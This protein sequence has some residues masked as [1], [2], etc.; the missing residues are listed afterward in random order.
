MG[1]D[2]TFDG[3][4]FEDR[5]EREHAKN[6]GPSANK[7]WRDGMISARELCTQRFAPL[8][9]IVPGT[10]PEGL[11]ILAGRPKIGKSCWF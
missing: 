6:Y 9:F 8:K 10:I 7:D 2:Y 11:T 3:K 1:D 5:V 4:R